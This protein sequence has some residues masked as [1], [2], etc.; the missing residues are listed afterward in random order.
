MFTNIFQTKRNSQDNPNKSPSIIKLPPLI[1]KAS[2]SW[3]LSQNM[4]NEAFY[5]VLIPINRA[6]FS[7]SYYEPY[8]SK[9]VLR[10]SQI[11]SRFF[12]KLKLQNWHKIMPWWLQIVPWFLSNLH[13][14][15]LRQFSIF[16]HLDS[17]LMVM[18]LKPSTIILIF[19]FS[20]ASNYYM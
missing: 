13:T 4:K 6:R 2:L 7:H 16:L 15:I 9:I 19:I 8:L 3:S 17:K 12:S 20:I 18:P 14:S 11:V 1:S 5:R 10:F